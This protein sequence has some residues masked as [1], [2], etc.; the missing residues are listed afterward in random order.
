MRYAEVVEV[1]FSVRVKIELFLEFIYELGY[2]IVSSE[3]RYRNAGNKKL[4]SPGYRLD[5]LNLK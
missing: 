3:P 2:S 4:D 1:S 5:N